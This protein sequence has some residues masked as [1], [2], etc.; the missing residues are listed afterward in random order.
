MASAVTWLSY[1]NP[2]YELKYSMNAVVRGPGVKSSADN[3]LGYCWLDGDS[4][5]AEKA[6]QQTALMEHTD[7]AGQKLS[8]LTEL[9]HLQTPDHNKLS[10][11]FGFD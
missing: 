7:I 9:R 10:Q 2:Q 4:N 3:S 1:T 11:S 8:C 6:C 5:R